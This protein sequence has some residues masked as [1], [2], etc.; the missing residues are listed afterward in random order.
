M[1]I[2]IATAIKY[3]SLLDVERLET[4]DGKQKTILSNTNRYTW[5]RCIVIVVVPRDIDIEL[6]NQEEN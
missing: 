6:E 2:S 4:Q 5:Y 1:L 3:F